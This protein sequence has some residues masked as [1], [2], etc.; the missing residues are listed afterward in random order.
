MF[1]ILLVHL[2]ITRIL[3]VMY[4]LYILRPFSSF[5]LYLVIAHQLLCHGCV[6]LQS[7]YGGKHFFLVS[8]CLYI[9]TGGFNY[10]ASPFIF[11]FD[12]FYYMHLCDMVFLHTSMIV[13][14]SVMFTLF[15]V[16]FALI[17]SVSHANMLRCSLCCPVNFEIITSVVC[18]AFVFDLYFFAHIRLYCFSHAIYDQKL[19]RLSLSIL[20]GCF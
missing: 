20:I 9:F 17:F 19:F 5:S 13:F 2:V 15:V 6:H 1:G 8:I 18:F 12:I 11:F 10:F 14:V 3:S 16:L 4:F 7:F